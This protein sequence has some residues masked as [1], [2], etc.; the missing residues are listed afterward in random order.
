MIEKTFGDFNCISCGKQTPAMFVIK[1][2]TNYPLYKI[3]LCRD[4][5]NKFAEDVISTLRKKLDHSHELIGYKRKENVN[6]K[7]K[8]RQMNIKSHNHKKMIKELTSEE[9]D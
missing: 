3:P 2:L 4:C 6:L 8:V 1:D 7:R 5:S 9:S